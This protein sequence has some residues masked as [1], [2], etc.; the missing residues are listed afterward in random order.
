MRAAVAVLRTTRYWLALAPATAIGALA[1]GIPTDVLPNPWFTRMTPVRPLDLVLWPVLS[2]ALGALLATYA[3]PSGRPEG[4]LAGGAG[5]GVLGVFAIGCPI[6]NK[7]V[8]LA[9]GMSG[10]LTWF[11]PLQPV[12]GVLAVAVTL[13]ALRTRLRSV[14]DGCAVPRRLAQSPGETG[15]GRSA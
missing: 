12:L 6:C 15:A 3:L 2:L 1:T 13:V 8:V 9:L 14:A 5:G 11:E 7:L 10:A 4:S